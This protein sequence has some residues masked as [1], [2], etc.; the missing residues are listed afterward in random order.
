MPTQLMNFTWISRAQNISTEASL[1]T[2]GENTQIS[3]NPSFSKRGSESPNSA[4]LANCIPPLN[5]FT[6]SGGLM[7]FLFSA[8]PRYGQ[9]RNLELASQ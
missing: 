4:D 3:P 9:L 5:V 2:D 1:E 8:Q 6:A 7:G